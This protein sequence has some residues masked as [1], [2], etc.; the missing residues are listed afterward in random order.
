MTTLDTIIKAIEA[1]NKRLVRIENLLMT[2]KPAPQP[3]EARPKELDL[4]SVIPEEKE[5]K[6][7][8][9]MPARVKNVIRIGTLGEEL[10]IKTKNVREIAKYL[11]LEEPFIPAEYKQDNSHYYLTEASAQKVRNYVTNLIR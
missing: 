3:R 8:R 6:K 5:E 7:L 9:K 11:G 2:E 4:F 1:T 10:G